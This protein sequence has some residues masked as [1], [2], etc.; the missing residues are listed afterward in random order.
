MLSFMARKRHKGVA[1]AA[2]NKA[3]AKES[4]YKISGVIIHLKQ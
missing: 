3:V 2:I 4:A 1:I